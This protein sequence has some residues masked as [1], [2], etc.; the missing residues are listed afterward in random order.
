MKCPECQSENREGA[1]FC[2]ECGHKFELVCPSCGSSNR[3][4]SKFC[5]ECG[6]DLRQ[7]TEKPTEVDYNRP[8][9]Y[10]PKHLAEKI[11]TTR[12]SIEGEPKLVTVLFADVANYTSSAEK[13]DPAESSGTGNYFMEVRGLRP[14]SAQGYLFLGELYTETGE[15]EALET[16]RKAEDMFRGIGTGL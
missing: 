13:L 4:G 8:Q 11:L 6:H 7:P 3:V 16:L 15:E 14:H 1:K 5:D 2:N 9:S 10:A 12:S